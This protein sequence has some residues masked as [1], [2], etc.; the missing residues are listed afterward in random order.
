MLQPLRE[1][2]MRDLDS[3]SYYHLL[4]AKSGGIL[5]RLT[6]ILNTLTFQVSSFFKMRQIQ[7][8]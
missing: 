5:R 7:D 3:A 6:P 1:N 8:I 2:L 4:E